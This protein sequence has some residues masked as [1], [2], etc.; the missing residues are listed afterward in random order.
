MVYPRYSQLFP[1][2]RSVRDSLETSYFAA[3]KE[4]EAKAAELYASD[5][6]SAIKYLN[7]YSNDKAQQMLASWH[8]LAKLIIVTYN[9]MAVKK[10][11]DGRITRSVTR[12]GY[13]AS[14]AKKLVKETGDWY[15]VPTNK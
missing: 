13:P 14:F 12:P 11:K 4:V 8:E 15:E 9:D 3:Q 6:Q 5:K 2:L 10:V 7:G 1:E